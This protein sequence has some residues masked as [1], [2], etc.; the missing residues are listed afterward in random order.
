MLI[1]THAHLDQAEFEADLDDVIRRAEESGVE[2]IVSIGLD[3]ASNK[4]TIALAE[5]YTNIW[6]AIGIHP[7]LA[8]T[9][10]EA[11]LRDLRAMAQHPRVVAIG[12]TGLD[13]Y[14]N[15]APRDAQI[16]AFQTQLALAREFGLPV[17]IHDR[18]AHSEVMDI[19]KKWATEGPQEGKFLGVLHCF[20]GDIALAQEA[21]SYGFAISIAGPIT[22]PNSNRLAEVVRNVPDSVLVVETDCPFLPPQQ[23]RGKRNEPAYVKLTAER[24]AQLRSQPV[25]AIAQITTANARRLFRFSAGDNKFRPD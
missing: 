2:A 4:A 10:N 14:R 11:T 16:R 18:E 1:D 3:T 24:L 6:A 23:F 25:E 15:R 8:T 12:E 5:K 20:S 13:F 22:Y 9:L 21:I 19:V 7:H 17:V